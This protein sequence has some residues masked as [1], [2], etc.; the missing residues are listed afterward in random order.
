VPFNLYVSFA[1][2]A[3]ENRTLFHITNYE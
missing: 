2:E 3:Y 1:K